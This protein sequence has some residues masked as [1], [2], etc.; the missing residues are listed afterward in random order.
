MNLYLNLDGVLHPN[1]VAYRPGRAPELE[2]EGHRVLEHAHLLTEVL[3]AHED[4]G[5]VLNTWWTYYLGFDT[6]LNLL[7]AAL[8]SRVTGAVLGFSASYCELP[9][10]VREA[11]TRITDSRSDAYLILD[12]SNARYLRCY[13]PHLLAVNESEG[14]ATPQAAQVLRRRIDMIVSEERMKMRHP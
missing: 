5:I 12:H 3:A 13:L 1:Q 2:I 8:A 9:H 7:S 6:C 4:V 14:M 11:E 10:R